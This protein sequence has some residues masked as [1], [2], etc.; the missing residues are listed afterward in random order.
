MIRKT[1]IARAVAMALGLVAIGASVAPSAYAQSNTT[2]SI[3]GTVGQPA[4]TEVL[5]E[6]SDTGAKRSI[7]PDASGRFNLVSLPTGVYNITLT[8]N[9]AVVEKRTGIEVILSQGAE[10]SFGGTTVVEVRGSAI[11]RLDLSSA[12]STTTFTARDLEKIPVAPNVGAIIQLAPNTTR[13]DSR[14]GGG[15]APSFGGASA[16]ENAYYINGFPVTTLLTQVGFSQL[17]FNSIAQAQVL[18]GGYGAEFGRSTGGVV[19]LITKRGG[20]D[21][22]VGGAISFEPNGL[23]AK[24]RD[25]VY[26]AN[27]SSLANKMYFYNRLNTQDRTIISAYG[28]GALIKDRQYF[29]RGGHGRSITDRSSRATRRN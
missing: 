9:G 16:S 1:A 28:S 6:N 11:R 17:P 22:E 14:Y 4:G 15:G 8:R 18:T 2:G 3:Y 24:E 20:N 25:Q 12:G 27:G 21:F 5:V 23:R 10:V 7:K 13:G 29:R 19:N 26:A